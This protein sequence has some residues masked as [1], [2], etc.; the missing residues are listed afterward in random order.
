MNGKPF[1]LILSVVIIA[2]ICTAA[3]AART[4][5]EVYVQHCAMCHQSGAMG[6][7]VYGTSVWAELAEEGLDMLVKDAIRGKKSMPPRG[8]CGDCSDQEIR[9]AVK[10]MMD[11]AK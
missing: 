7:P 6:A 11:S 8:G 9:D 1:A 3:M 4:G 2:L 5:Q 10:Y